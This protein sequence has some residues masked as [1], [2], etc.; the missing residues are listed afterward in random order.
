MEKLAEL[1]ELYT[2]NSCKTF[3]NLMFNFLELHAKL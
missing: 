3:T 2:H 1:L